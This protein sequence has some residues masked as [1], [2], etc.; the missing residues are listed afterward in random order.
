MAKEMESE[1][2]VRFDL[3]WEAY[4]R[5]Q[6][7]IDAMKAWRG[8]KPSNDDLLEICRGINRFIACGE[9][10]ERKFIP[11]PATFLR[12]RRWEDE[13]PEP[14]LLKQPEV[15]T[16]YCGV[17]GHTGS[18]HAREVRQGRQLDHEFTQVAVP[19]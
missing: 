16:R 17:C 1:D 7:K 9:W 4:P 5:R 6:G 14:I 19:A 18:W 11:Y 8:M 10:K 3:F 12:G 2:R 13:L 15:D